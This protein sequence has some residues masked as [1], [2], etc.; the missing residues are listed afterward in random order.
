M[1]VPRFPSS[2]DRIVFDDVN[3]GDAIGSRA[4]ACFQHGVDVAIARV[5]RD[6]LIG[7]VIFTNFTGESIS[8]HTASWDGHWVNRDLLFVVF[9]YPF[10]QLGVKRIFG[11][12]PETNTQAHSFN[13]HCGFRDVA[14]IEGVY[15]HNVA[16]IVMR[17]D[18]EDCRFFGVKP[19][20]IKTNLN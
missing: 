11:R 6:K 4:G 7:G 19:R 8:I 5:R 18:R 3:H 12:L 17:L 9:D 13:L 14:R 20:G 2:S 10:N 1:T 15:K 16:Q